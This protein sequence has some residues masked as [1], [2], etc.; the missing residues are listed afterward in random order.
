MSGF[1]RLKPTEL[2]A[3]SRLMGWDL[4]PNEVEALLELTDAMLVPLKTEAKR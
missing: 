3:M 1:Q 2:E 4:R